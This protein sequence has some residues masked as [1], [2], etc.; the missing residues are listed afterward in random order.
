MTGDFNKD[1]VIDNATVNQCG[2]DPACASGGSVSILLGKLDGGLQT[3]V[4]YPTG[5]G[6]STRFGIVGD[7]NGNLI[8]DL[9]V[10][11]FRARTEFPFS[12]ASG[13]GLS[14]FGHI[15]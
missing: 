1:G 12:L 5:N 2:R 7:S 9:A 4:D 6:G 11:N 10:A 13:T 15:L 3:A 8:L 14:R